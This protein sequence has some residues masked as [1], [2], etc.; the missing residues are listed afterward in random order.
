[1]LSRRL[2]VLLVLHR[3]LVCHP[4]DPYR[5]DGSLPVRRCESSAVAFIVE[6]TRTEVTRG[7]A[8]M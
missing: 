3:V 2:W 8:A 6:Y 4:V 5:T 1:M 7:G